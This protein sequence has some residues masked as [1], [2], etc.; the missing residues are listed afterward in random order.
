MRQAEAP[1][2]QSGGFT[3]HP[4]IASSGAYSIVGAAQRPRVIDG[5]LLR[6]QRGQNL[7]AGWVH[8]S[9]VPH[10]TVQFGLEA[11]G[12]FK[13]DRYLVSVEGERPGLRFAT[14]ENP[15]FQ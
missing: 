1:F 6:V 14:S 2:R 3:I 13:V 10:F 12:I 15:A 7:A 5:L 11:V 8:G 4:D 9:S